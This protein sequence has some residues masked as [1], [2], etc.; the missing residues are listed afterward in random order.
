MRHG[1]KLAKFRHTYIVTM[2]NANRSFIPMSITIIWRTENGDNLKE[3]N[4][5]RLLFTRKLLIDGELRKFF[6]SFHLL[7]SSPFTV[8]PNQGLFLKSGDFQ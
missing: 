8:I 3:K 4:V 6:E 7:L 5:Y 2:H 1:V